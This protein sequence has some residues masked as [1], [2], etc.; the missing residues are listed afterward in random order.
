MDFFRQA[1]EALEAGQQTHEPTLT[2]QPSNTGIPGAPSPQFAL[3]NFL[4]PGYSVLMSVAHSYMGTDINAYVPFLIVVAALYVIWMYVWDTLGDFFRDYFTSSVLIPADDEIYNMVMLWVSKQKFAHSSRS[5]VANTNIN[6]RHHLFTYRYYDNESDAEDEDDDESHVDTTTGLSNNQKQALHY[7][8]GFNGAHFFWYKS[9]P[10]T[11]TRTIRERDSKNSNGWPEKEELTITTIGRNPRILKELLLEARQIH[12]TKDD[13]KTAI[14]RANFVDTYWQ[15]CMSR[16]NR[17][18][19]TVILN[20]DVK[21]DLIDDAADY[22]DPV[23]RRWYANRGIPYRRGY[24]LHGPPGTGKS[25]LSLALAG[26]FRMKIYIVSLSSA[27]ATEENLM[28]LFHDLPTRCVVLLEDI[29]SAGLT[30][31]RDTPETPASPA[32][33][34]SKTSNSPSSDSTSTSGSRLSLSGLLNIL[35]GV[36]SQEGRILIMTTNHIEK[37]DKAL[38]R[39]GRVDMTIHFGLADSN[40]IA[41][42]FRSIYAPYENETTSMAEAKDPDQEAIQKRLA[43]RRAKISERVDEQA[44]LFSQEIPEL[45]FSPAEVQGLLLRHK[46]DPASALA[47]AGAWVVQMRKDKKEKAEEDEKKQKEEQEKK[48]K[49]KEK[50]KEKED[51]K[52]KEKEKGKD[53]E[54]EKEKEQAKGNN[55]D[56]GEDKADQGKND[57]DKEHNSGTEEAATHDASNGLAPKESDT[58][59]KGSSD[60]GYETP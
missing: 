19:S 25:S 12:M 4:L 20:E 7:T 24:L 59:K 38:I 6:S 10:F 23:T 60:S 2:S 8:P 16:L 33:A 26:Y 49:E 15:R 35:D 28:S 55:V 1:G 57:K 53:K 3:L 13:R 14:Y 52:E 5:F 46:R 21:Q 47:A 11:I 31:S 37:L 44:K 48:Q 30:H 17:P 27:A 54:K 58:R 41:S 9:W 29:D 32:D 36:A 56:G 45:E 51:E 43:K 18:F 22:L 40:M 39:P 34:D 50:E 42:I